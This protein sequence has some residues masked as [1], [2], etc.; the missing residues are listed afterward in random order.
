MVMHGN[1][2]NLKE[3]L[4]KFKDLMDDHDIEFVLLYGALLGAYRNKCLLPWDADIDIEVIAKSYEDFVDMDIFGLLRD[5]YKEGFKDAR[6]AHEFVVDT[7]YFKYPEIKLL[8]ENE[9]WKEF[10]R[11]DPNWR[12]ERFGMH[13]KSGGLSSSFISSSI[14]LLKERNDNVYIDCLVLVKGIHKSY[15]WFYEGKLGKIELYGEVFNTPLDIEFYLSEYYG[16]NWR[17]V[18]C[19][20]ELWS[21]HCEELRLGHVP[22]EVEDFMNK[23][24][25]LL[26]GD[27]GE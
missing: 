24:K 1:E 5:A 8:P 23:W 4:F 26:E 9:Q 11:V 17:D 20:Y 21:K 2:A 15:G 14:G 22:Q 16:K 3:A 7:G 6:W 25:P 12:D 13:W 19:S 18:F 27:E 10:L